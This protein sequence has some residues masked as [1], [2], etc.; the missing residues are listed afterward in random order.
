MDE[1]TEAREAY[2]LF[3]SDVKCSFDRA[4]HIYTKKQKTPSEKKIMDMIGKRSGTW[5]GNPCMFF[6]MDWC[7]LTRFNQNGSAGMTGK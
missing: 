7:R 5:C 6:R 4:Y 2:Y 1:M 3:M